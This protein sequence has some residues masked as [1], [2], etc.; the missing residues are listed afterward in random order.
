[1][2]KNSFDS[3]TNI[4]SDVVIK[5]IFEAKVELFFRHDKIPDWQESDKTL[6]IAETYIHT[7]CI[8]NNIDVV[9]NE[10]KK[11]W[12]NKKPERCLLIHFCDIDMEEKVFK[13]RL[14]H[15]VMF[16]RDRF[17]RP[18]IRIN[19]YKCSQ[20]TYITEELIVEDNK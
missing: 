9:I 4:K 2:P 15:F 16:L 17:I 11:L 14:S 5:D 18:Y 10:G 13:K 8:Y 7:Y 3:D 12:H 19:V 6:G 20:Q 1:M